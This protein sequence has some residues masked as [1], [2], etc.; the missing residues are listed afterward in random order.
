VAEK[1]IDL[2]YN[3]DGTLATIARDQG[4]QLVV[5]N[6]KGVRTVFG[7]L[8]KGE[9]PIRPKSAPQTVAMPSP[10]RRST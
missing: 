3:A 1:E 9:L 6:G 2:T 5:G 10:R 7:R 8:G 4:G